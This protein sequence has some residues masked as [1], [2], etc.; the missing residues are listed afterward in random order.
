MPAA[1]LELPEGPRAGVFL[2]PA[3][4]M[5][6]RILAWRCC[7]WMRGSSYWARSHQTVAFCFR[8]RATYEVGDVPERVDD[9]RRRASLLERFG[10]PV[11][12]LVDE[13]GVR[14]SEPWYCEGYWGC[15]EC[16]VEEVGEGAPG[17][18]TP[19]EVV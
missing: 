14:R 19:E 17:G 1:M 12:E 2:P 11:V 6:A 10:V 16:M 9:E 18:K 7:A 5:L 15:C 3:T 13:V 8:I 4:S